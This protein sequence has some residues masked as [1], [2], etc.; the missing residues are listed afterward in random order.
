[1]IKLIFKTDSLK[2]QFPKDLIDSLEKLIQPNPALHHDIDKTRF[3]FFFG[4]RTL[5]KQNA[6]YR[7]EA[8]P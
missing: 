8:H 4:F 3:F 6:K 5:I 2:K 7:L 1:M